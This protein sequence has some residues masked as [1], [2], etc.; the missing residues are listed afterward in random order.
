MGR[1]GER[2][3]A[4]APAGLPVTAAA[5]R[6]G[7]SAST[8]RSWERRYGLGPTLRTPG[9]HRRYSGADLAALQQLQQLIAAGMATATAARAVSPKPP[10][11]RRVSGPRDPA[12]QLR[13]AVDVLDAGRALRAAEK[14]LAERGPALAWTDV[15]APLLRRLGER[16]GATGEGTEREHVASDAVGHALMGYTRRARLLPGRCAL[17][18]VAAPGEGHVLPLQALV[19]ALAEHAVPAQVLTALPPLGLHAAV[20]ALEPAVLLVWAHSAETAD[21][22][23]PGALV[24]QVPAVYVGGPGWLGQLPAA[25][26]ALPDLPAAVAA[27][28]AWAG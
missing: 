24:G 9:G 23:V 5:G 15:F 2:E 18:A 1:N 4:P 25:V 13:A 19:A 12:E 16:W 17:L 6:L 7:L 27:V 8:L 14:V 22:R 26:S 11:G 21:G 28:R 10:R 20:D 3:T